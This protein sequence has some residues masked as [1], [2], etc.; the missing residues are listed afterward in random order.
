MRVLGLS[1]D[2]IRHDSSLCLVEGG[3]LVYASSEDRFSKLK[4]DPRAPLL[5]LEYILDKRHLSLDDIDAIAIGM[6]PFKMFEG[7]FEEGDFGALFRGLW[8]VFALHPS[9]L[10]SYFSRRGKGG[11]RVGFEWLPQEK[12][13]YISH[14][15]AHGASA[16]R[17]SGLNRALSVNMDGA[18]CDE[19]GRPL[20]GSVY[21][22][23][24]GE[25]QLFETVP[26]Y[27][28]MGCFYNAVTQACGFR[29]V[30]ED[31]K[32]MGL[33]AFG[34]SEPAYAE[35]KP[36]APRYVKG[37]WEVTPY[38]VQAKLID[39]PDILRQ[40]DLWQHLAK[41][42]DKYGDRNS[43]AAAQRVLEENLLEY[44]SALIEKTGEKNIVL[45]GGVFHN[46]KFNMRLRPHIPEGGRLFVHPAAGDPGTAVGAALELY[47]RLSG[48]KKLPEIRSMA[49]GAEYDENEIEGELVKK[50]KSLKWER[51]QNFSE[52]VARLLS[53]EKVVGLFY[54]ASEWGPRA[55]GNRSVL[56]CPR[57]PAMRERINQRLKKREWFMPFA[58]AILEEDVH[59][60][61]KDPVCSPFMTE[62]FFATDYAKETIPSAV[63]SDG[64]VRA[65]TVCRSTM[66]HFYDIL[67]AF[68]E[69]TGIGVLLNTSF[70]RHGL[71]TINAP[72]DAVNHLLWGCVD[73]LA[74]GPFIVERLYTEKEFKKRL[75]WSTD[76]IIGKW[77]PYD[78]HLNAIREKR[79]KEAP[80]LKV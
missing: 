67:T 74:I 62:A 4:H 1:A 19:R 27:A 65:Q 23:S 43:A 21:L 47:T 48:T 56:A 35:M 5:A 68:K 80:V 69:L 63:H 24:D 8:G 64:T 13:H 38:T 54:G 60:F 26:R 71:P 40:T 18:G 3:R 29:P 55:L 20:S 44:V 37:R 11:G 16:Y 39:R 49:L 66:P 33:A 46:I 76:E 59:L 6:P 45:A 77:A 51:P 41:I 61:V 53:E 75:N 50:R 72:D 52:K 70:N 15:L 25:M 9:Q 73:L 7:F 12:V 2:S 32:M 57:N 22:C 28:S 79:K 34:D 36:L 10:K 17:T 14:Y 31:W 30:G 42:L 58:P 78:A